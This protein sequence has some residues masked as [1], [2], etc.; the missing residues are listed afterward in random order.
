MPFD[1][2]TPEGNFYVLGKLTN[3]KLDKVNRM[4]YNY[5]R[6]GY[7]CNLYVKQGY[8]N[9]LYA[10]LKDKSKAGDETLMEGNHW[11]TENDYTIYVYH[12]QRG[13]FYDQLVGVKRLNSVRR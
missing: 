11:E 6:F 8:Y 12:R 2:P 10:F 9:Y 1:N 7:E 5:K 13:T 3:W 4:T